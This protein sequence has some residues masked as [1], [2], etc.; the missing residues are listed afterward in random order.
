MDRTTATPA[1]ISDRIWRRCWCGYIPEETRGGGD[2]TGHDVERHGGGD[3][4]LTN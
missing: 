2:V 3:G 1:R 4:G